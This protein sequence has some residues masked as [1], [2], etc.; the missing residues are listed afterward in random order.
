MVTILEASRWSAWPEQGGVLD[1]DAFLLQD[2]M[3][4]LALRR[5]IEWEVKGRDMF[6]ERE[7][8]PHFTME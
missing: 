8:V 6:A 2:V 4:Y 7:D 5:R 1:Q 3:T